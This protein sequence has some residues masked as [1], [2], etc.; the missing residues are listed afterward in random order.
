L[1]PDLTAL[2]LIPLRR[3]RNGFLRA[4]GQAWPRR[5]FL[6][7]VALVLLSTVFGLFRVMFGYF[8]RMPMIGSLLV[9]RMVSMVF[10][11]FLFMLVYSNIMSSLSSHFLSR[12]LPILFASPLK[13]ASIFTAKALEAL[14]GSSWMVVLMCVPLYAAYGWVRHA[15]GSFYLLALLATVPFLLIPASLSMAVNTAMMYFFPARRLKEAMILVG[16][17]MFSAAVILFRMMEPEKLVNPRN[18]MQIFEYVKLISAPSA[19]WLPSAWMGTAV[20]AAANVSADPFAYWVNLGKLCGLA[21]LFW[22]GAVAL[23]ARWYRGAWQSATESMGVRRGVRLAARWLPR[24]TG[25]YASILLKDVKVFIREPAQWGQVLLLAALVLIYL[26]NLTRIPGDVA[27]GLRGMLFFLNMGLIGWILTAVAAR[28][29]FPLVS[30]EGASFEL[31]RTA[32]LSMERYLWTRLLGGL[33]PLVVL[34]AVL[35]GISIPLLGV[36]RFMGSI[37]AFTIMGM[38]LAIS[39]MAVGCGAGFA[40]FRISNP[41]EIVTSAGGFLF[42][43][44]SMGYIVVA[45]LVEAQPVRLYYWSIL[46]RRPFDHGLMT[47][48]A[49]A[50]VTLMTA[51]AVWVPIRLGARSLV[52]REL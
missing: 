34:A 19:P 48:G 37:A 17:V 29:L 49:L 52:N 43:A 33:A 45:L 28:F 36:D 22:A 41:E 21:A 23:A 8:Y 14:F 42:M 27:Q 30:L 32:P 20:I 3:A 9:S 44:L 12:D 4:Q 39:A 35:T 31:L 15:S 46:M 6:F 51:V 10:L 1:N 25:P 7:L 18:E 38:T 5:I 24:E 11:T 40:R 2:F 50:I 16:T 13:P 47:A 26:F